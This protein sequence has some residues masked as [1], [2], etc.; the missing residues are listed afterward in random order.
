MRLIDGFRRVISLSH[1]VSDKWSAVQARI[2]A[3]R[4]LRKL[5]VTKGLSH[6]AVIALVSW[7]EKIH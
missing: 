3:I 5:I 7:G 6:P 1:G 2:E 4:C